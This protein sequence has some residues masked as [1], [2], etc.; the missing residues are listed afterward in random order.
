ML[1][2][3][4]M[5]HLKSQN[6]FAV[7]LDLLIVIVGVFLGFQVNAW[8]EARKNKA[9][10]NAA[11]LRLQSEAEQVVAYWNYE[12]KSERRL[13]E[14]R[15]VLLEVLDAGAMAESQQATVDDA[16][17]RLGHYPHFNPPRTVYDE[18]V[19]SGGLATISDSDVR[20]S[21]AAYAAEVDFASGQLT[22]FRT[23]LP[24]LYAAYEGRI[25]SVY[26]R[27]RPS[28][29]RFEYDIAA[30]AKDRVFVSDMVDAV[31]NQLQFLT[32]RENVA[33]RAQAM[34]ETVSRSVGT[35]CDPEEIS[36]EE[37]RL[38]D[39]VNR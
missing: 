29:R 26:E 13:N 22:Q 12:V 38:R 14:N 28:K 21:V 30:L 5:E 31:R 6:W 4:M 1:L 7:V 35:T 33:R 27:D 17:L 10:E 15:L 32:I 3:R 11:L 16:I 8:N 18:L 37:I 2:R 24:T 19:A 36:D 23:N 34:C 9:E 20:H 39:G 25:F